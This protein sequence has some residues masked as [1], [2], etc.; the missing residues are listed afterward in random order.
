MNGLGQVQRDGQD[1]GGLQDKLGSDD[2]FGAAAQPGRKPA[3]ET[4]IL[5]QDAG[6]ERTQ[7]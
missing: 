3:A 6:G 5:I 4:Q 2:P 7:L 1:Y